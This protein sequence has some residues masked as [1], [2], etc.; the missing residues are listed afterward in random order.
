MNNQSNL[1]SELKAKLDQWIGQE[2]LITKEEDGDID[3]TH[4]SLK[5]TDIEQVNSIDD[6]VLPF[7]LR[8]KGSGEVITDD[9]ESPLPYECY[10][11]PF[12]HITKSSMTD[13]EL[14]FQTDRAIYKLHRK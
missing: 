6:Y 5:N 10:E 11:I 12:K 3:K 2:L 13:A 7:V 1:G 9:G 8:L 14:S 4:L